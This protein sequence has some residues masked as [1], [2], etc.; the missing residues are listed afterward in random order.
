MAVTTS[1]FPRAAQTS[2]FHSGE[3]ALTCVS[4][5]REIKLTLPEL[6]IEGTF[7]LQE[8]LANMELP[9]LLG[10]GA[11]L[12]RISDANLTVGK[13]QYTFL[14]LKAMPPAQFQPL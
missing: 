10:K 8:L 13:V 11:D 2:C 1:L 12:S 5:C 6:T 7:D 3:H 4:F 9:T 14:P